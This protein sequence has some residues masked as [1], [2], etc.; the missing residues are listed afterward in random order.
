VALVTGPLD[1]GRIAAL[2]ASP[3]AGGSVLFVGTVRRENRGREVIRLHYE[4]YEP[5]AVKVIESILDEARDRF[6]VLEL[7]AHHRLG[8]LG[9]GEVA[10]VVAVSSAHRAEAFEASRYVI[11][12]LKTRAPIWKKELYRDGESRLSHC[13]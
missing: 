9:L 7:A 10:V 13:P 3:A 1:P 4:A 2:V 11:D 12:E 8:D 5:M 6:G